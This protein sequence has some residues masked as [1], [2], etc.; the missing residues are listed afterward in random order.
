MPSKM[1]KFKP[2]TND[3]KSAINDIFTSYLFYETLNKAGDRE[4]T[5]SHCGKTFLVN[6]LSRTETYNDYMLQR[7]YHNEEYNCPKCGVRCTV[8]NKGKAKSCQNLYEQQ[9]VCVIQTSGKNKVYIQCFYAE[10]SY[11]GGIYNP[12]IKF[13]DACK[14]YLT[15]TEQH[16]Y[17]ENWCS[18]WGE[19]NVFSEP[20]LPKCSMGYPVDNSYTIIGLNRLSK[21]FLRYNML[22]EYAQ[23]REDYL[24]NACRDLMKADIK[25][26][27]YLVCFAKYP[28]LE[29]L[30]KLGHYDVVENLVEVGKKSF[31]YV[32]WRAKS[33]YRF[34]KMDKQEYKQFL[35]A[36][37][38]L[39]LL[40]RK[41]I[42]SSIVANPTW[43]KVGEYVN[44]CGGYYLSEAI[45]QMKRFH[46]PVKEGV[47]YLIKQAKAKE[48]KFSSVLW[49]FRDYYNM[50]S[51]LN[52]DIENP[53]VC[54]PKNLDE[55]HDNA[56]RNHTVLLQKRYEKQERQKLKEYEKKKKEY[57]KQYAFSDG[58]FSIIIPSGIEDI[59]REGKLQE[60][61]VGGYAH[62]HVN[63][64]LTICF[65]RRTDD[66]DT[67]LYT[68]EMHGRLLTQVQGRKNKTP[69]T[70]E[71]KMFF[72]AWLEWV[73]NGSKR[74]RDGTP[75]LVT[76][77]ANKTA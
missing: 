28:Q 58:E 66:I 40:E 29:M 54:F 20:F 30:Q 33:I 12:E 7:L 49:D 15:P 6:S 77:A 62:R 32:S 65:L 10:K 2:L 35:T 64:A 76:I 31:P 69:L 59:I 1:P 48:K 73:R 37:G 46:L 53:V 43:Q 63:G 71:A 17:K 13:H 26:I 41:N 8:K 68:I 61:C 9:R 3:E 23:R 67:P 24:L 74:N 51:E 14:Y 72:D 25:M 52:Y 4:Y 50:A 16:K 38:T 11:L 56:N 70:P 44:S 47:D 39:E 34:F 27:K 55:A 5:C 42:V 60:H 21:T 36:G 57:E 45:E 18:G 75:K 19:Y 22:E